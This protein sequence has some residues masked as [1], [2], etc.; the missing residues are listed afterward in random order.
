MKAFSS[1]PSQHNPRPRPVPG[2]FLKKAPLQ[3]TPA[4]FKFA[5]SKAL[6]IAAAPIA[7]ASGYGEGGGS[8]QGDIFNWAA[9]ALFVMA[10]VLVSLLGNT[11]VKWA[12]NKRDEVK[13]ENSRPV[14]PKKSTFER[15]Y[16]AGCI[17]PENSAPVDGFAGGPTPGRQLAMRNAPSSISRTATGASPR[18][19]THVTWEFGKP[20]AASRSSEVYL[21][22]HGTTMRANRIVPVFEV[23]KPEN[24]NVAAIPCS[25]TRAFYMPPDENSSA[26]WNGY[27][28][29]GRHGGNGHGG[30][31]RQ[32]D[33]PNQA[34]QSAEEISDHVGQMLGY[35]QTVKS[36]GATL[37]SENVKDGL[38]E[39][40]QH[41]NEEKSF[42]M[43]GEV[44]GG[45]LQGTMQSAIR[46]LIKIE[47]F[48]EWAKKNNASEI[49]S[50]NLSATAN[51]FR[52]YLESNGLRVENADST[53]G[54]RNYAYGNKTFGTTRVTYG[55]PVSRPAG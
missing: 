15:I 40:V 41:L 43:A 7:T 17:M 19:G 31:G 26:G 32:A 24:L 2:E 5:K 52:E 50:T 39:L 29:N 9:G 20:Q 28:G 34:H 46:M 16:S 49:L 18:G 30:N 54:E 10:T 37:D 55:V 21:P 48:R 1:I 8:G 36:H 45:N 51:S 44:S 35:L 27:G 25:P 33:T 4:K 47:H 42:V 23:V 22:Q 3:R 38:N 13:I 14:P 53:V 12:K 6:F 11:I